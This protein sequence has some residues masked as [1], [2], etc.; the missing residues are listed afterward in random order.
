MYFFYNILFGLTSDNMIMDL[1]SVSLL[2]I[3]THVA[4]G[5]MVFEH[6]LYIH[7]GEV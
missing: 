6:I 7:Y 4:K 5:H 3:A 1:F 2:A